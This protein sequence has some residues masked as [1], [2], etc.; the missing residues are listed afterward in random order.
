MLKGLIFDIQRYSIH[1]GPGIRTLIFM[2]GC[3]LRCLW[4]SNPESQL[5]KQEMMFNAVK[6]IGCGKCIE[7]CPTG[8]AGEKNPAK[9]KK[10]CRNCG[11]CGEVCPST[12]RQMVGKYMTVAEVMEEIERDVRFYRRSGGGI[13]VTGGEPLMQP[14]YV[15]ALLKECNAKDID[16]AIETCGYSDEESLEKVIPYVDLA[17]Y[18]IKHMDE[19]KH[20]EFTGDGNA[21]IL[22]NARLI[23]E[24]HKSMK[25]RIP[26]VPGYND[27]DENI[28][29]IAKFACTL[30]NVDEINLIP[31]HS[32]G[33]SKYNSLGKHYKLEGLN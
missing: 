18:D 6:C 26:V 25:I 31:Y 22:K 1:D 33:E 8:A 27:S 32:F 15:Q 13:T 16:T 3:P 28:E 19:E 10:I 17:L 20:K 29:N 12:A 21:K 24:K 23:V 30:N 2:K 14:E 7:V 5:Q 11:R 9:A 4:C